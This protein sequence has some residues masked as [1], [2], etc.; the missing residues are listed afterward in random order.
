MDEKPNPRI[1]HTSMRVALQVDDI[2]MH[3]IRRLSDIDRPGRR[4]KARWERIMS[5]RRRKAIPVCKGCHGGIH[6]GRYDGPKVV[7]GELESRVR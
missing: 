3:H 5:A 2:E 6:A 1:A 7:N 4:P